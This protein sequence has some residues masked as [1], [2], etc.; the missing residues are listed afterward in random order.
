MKYCW[1]FTF[2]Y[3]LLPVFTYFLTRF[4]SQ[5]QWRRKLKNFEGTRTKN[6]GLRGVSPSKT[7]PFWA[8]LFTVYGQFCYF[9]FIFF[10]FSFLVYP[11]PQNFRREDVPL[12]ENFQGQH[13]P[14]L[15]LSVL[16][17]HS[18]NMLHRINH[19]IRIEIFYGSA[20]RQYL[21]KRDA[22]L[23]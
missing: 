21:I 10:N 23:N 14:L 18:F 20:F 2:L 11:P 12:T 4:V 8:H 16:Q 17:V 22:P 9:P 15:P 19:K 13:I 6:S 1:K 5:K 3:F 7:H